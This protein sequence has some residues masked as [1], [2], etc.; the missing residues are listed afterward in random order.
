M[1]SGLGGAIA[2]GMAFGG[3]SAVA[4]RAVD[5]VA[6]PREMKVSHDH[7]D[8]GADGA[9]AGAP[10]AGAG[11]GA[12]GY[13]QEPVRECSRYSQQMNQCLAENTENI[14]MC[15]SYVDMMRSCERGEMME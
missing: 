9:G 13:S 8:S 4:H 15:Q 5:A 12:A 2:Q 7:G 3:G 6:G 11:A 14:G 10:S 1:M